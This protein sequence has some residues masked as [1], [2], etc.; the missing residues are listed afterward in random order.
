MFRGYMQSLRQF[1]ISIWHSLRRPPI[2][3]VIKE[4]VG[5]APEPQVKRLQRQLERSRKRR[6][7]KVS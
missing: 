5:R 4:K 1:L 3:E 6:E 2:E 7:T